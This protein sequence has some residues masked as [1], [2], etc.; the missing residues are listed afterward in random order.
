MIRRAL[1]IFSIL[2]T[3]AY[4]QVASKK[5]V[6]EWHKQMRQALFIPNPLPKLEV[7]NYITFTPALGVVA[8]RVSYKTEY[9]LRVPAIVYRPATEPKSKVPGMVLVN[10][11]GADKTSWYAYYTAILYAKAGAVVVTYDPIGEGESNDDHQDGVGEHDKKILD[12]P[13]MPARMGGLMITDIMQAVSYVI[14]RRDVD[15]KRI[16]VLGFSM[17]SFESALAG[18]ADP[19]IHALLLTGGGDLDGT[20][21]YWD[22]S[23]IMC[24]GGPYRALAFLGDRGPVLYTLSARRGVTFILNGTNDT[25]VDIPHHEQDFFDDLRKRTIAL[26]G[27][28]R[29]VFETYFDPGA[30][31]RP[32]WM[33]PTAAAWLEKNLSFPNWSSTPVA[34]LPVEPMRTWAERVGLPLNKSSSR[35]D[36]DAGLPLLIAPAPLLTKEQL[37]IL[38]LADWQRRKSE[39]VYSTWVERILTAAKSAFPTPKP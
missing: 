5:Q 31:H 27:S 7:E 28:D 4:A 3:T 30:S 22:R 2:C 21:G 10:G 19:R 33:T 11:H 14:Q 38:P 37:S 23:A 24:Q 25:V 34:S 16:A 6:N 12:P 20:D 15:S 26:N 35:E 32:N 13:S 36:R 8:E 17:G 29:G 1:I 9:G 39:F 18:A